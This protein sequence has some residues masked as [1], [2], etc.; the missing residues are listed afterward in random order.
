MVVTRHT[1]IFKAHLLLAKVVWEVSN[2]DLG[3]G[4]NAILGRSALLARAKSISLASLVGVNGHGVLVTRGGRKSLVG[5]LGQRKD[6]ARHVG[7]SISRLGRCVSSLAL[8]VA[9]LR[10][11]GFGPDEFC[12]L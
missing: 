8:G 11:L 3:L 10:V 4:G 12:A 6:L 1:L 5:G 2:H 9:T 7:R